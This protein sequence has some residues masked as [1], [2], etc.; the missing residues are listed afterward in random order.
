MDDDED[1]A[2]WSSNFFSSECLMTKQASCGNSWIG[3]IFYK[4]PE[5][6]IFARHFDIHQKIF[7]RKIL[8]LLT[9][10]LVN[11]DPFQMP[12]IFLHKV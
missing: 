7:F 12:E 11:R 4:G 9:Y 5:P 1:V 3:K 10:S 2:G 6:Q 8:Y